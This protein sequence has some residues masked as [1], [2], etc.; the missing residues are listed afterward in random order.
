MDERY[1]PDRIKTIRALS[2]FIQAADELRAG[3]NVQPTKLMPLFRLCHS[4]KDF[5]SFAS[6]LIDKDF[7]SV[8]LTRHS[9]VTDID[10]KLNLLSET[11]D[12]LR[13]ESKEIQTDATTLYKKIFNLQPGYRRISI[14]TGFRRAADRELL[15]ADSA[16]F[17]LITREYIF[18][19]FGWNSYFLASRYVSTLDIR[20]NSYRAILKPE[21][22]PR[23]L[24]VVEYWSKELLDVGL[25]ELRI[26]IHTE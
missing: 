3:K 1:K 9:P 19:Y 4:R 12:I 8:E 6:Y 18:T 16:L 20:Y 23:I 10:N 2:K 5:A 24:D 11:L 7:A 25:A 17:P 15:L 14:H 21:S 26:L 13:Q 22:V